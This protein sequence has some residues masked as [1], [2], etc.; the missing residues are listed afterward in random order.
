MCVSNSCP[1]FLSD[2]VHLMQLSA[3]KHVTSGICVNSGQLAR[4]LMV[5]EVKEGVRGGMVWESRP[6][7]REVPFWL[8]L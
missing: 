4:R 6:K 5:R 1:T 2:W 3:Y 8:T 7:W